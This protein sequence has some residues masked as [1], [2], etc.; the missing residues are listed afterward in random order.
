MNA[1]RVTS[2]TGIGLRDAFLACALFAALIRAFIPA[3]FMPHVSDEGVSMVICTIDGARIVDGEAQPGAGGSEAMAAAQ[4]PCAF[5]ALATL[6]PPPQAPIASLAVAIARNIV[7]LDVS[8]AGSAAPDY[9][10]QAQRAP[11]SFLT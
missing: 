3:G 7:D 6:A 5:A 10:P 1:L 2:S 11:P 8:A 9:R 4:M